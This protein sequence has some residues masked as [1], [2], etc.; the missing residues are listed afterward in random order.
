MA[1]RRV[2]K[3]TEKPVPSPC[4]LVIS[5]AW[6]GSIHDISERLERPKHRT[7]FYVVG[8]VRAVID[9]VRQRDMQRKLARDERVPE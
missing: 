4:L 5:P 2:D 1:S 8:K 9:D 6:R 7:T 3:R